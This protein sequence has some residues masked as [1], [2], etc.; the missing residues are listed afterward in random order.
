MDPN[1]LDMRLEIERC[2]IHSEQNKKDI[3]ELG[4]TLRVKNESQDK[5]I[6]KL[7]ATGIRVY[8]YLAALASLMVT[9]AWLVD[10]KGM[11]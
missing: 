9:F 4:N 8:A 5:E 3:D 7:T 6:S 1:E 11:V 2:K 10:H